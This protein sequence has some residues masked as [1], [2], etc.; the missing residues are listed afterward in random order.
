MR[1]A[2]RL[3]EAVAVSFNGSTFRN[4]AK[5]RRGAAA[6]VRGTG[7]RELIRDERESP[8]AL[9]GLHAIALAEGGLVGV[10]ER[11]RPTLI[12][13]DGHGPVGFPVAALLDLVTGVRTCART[14]DR[15]D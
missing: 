10:S 13:L 14:R 15:R 1:C 8:A 4:P 7:K 9:D 5:K 3:R 11:V 6:P 2:R 12:H